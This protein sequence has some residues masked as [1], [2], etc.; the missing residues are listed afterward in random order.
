MF[1][2]LPELRLLEVPG[3]CRGSRGGV[4]AGSGSGSGAVAGGGEL[5]G[6]DMVLGLPAREVGRPRR[7][8]RAL[9]AIPEVPLLLH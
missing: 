3:S 7:G 8:R 1:S 2:P 6:A 9:G 4:R 5:S